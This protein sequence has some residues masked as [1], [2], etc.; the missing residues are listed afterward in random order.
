MTTFLNSAPSG[1]Q[2]ET[3]SDVYRSA[4]E[5]EDE[6]WKIQAVYVVYSE[7]RERDSTKGLF[8]YSGTDLW[9]RT[10]VH[11]LYKA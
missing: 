3:P 7:A 9:S 2:L 5:V 10:S 4:A 1:N 8:D 6:E 11:I